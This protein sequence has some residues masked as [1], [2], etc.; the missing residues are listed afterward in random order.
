MALKAIKTSCL[1]CTNP[2]ADAV[3]TLSNHGNVLEIRGYQCKVC[4]FNEVLEY[5]DKYPN[6]LKK[7]QG[8]K[9]IW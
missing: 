4:G 1:K 2:E 6:D 5:G 3:A 9:Q 8:Q 7:V